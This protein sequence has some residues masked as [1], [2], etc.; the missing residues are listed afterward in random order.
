MYYTCADLGFSYRNNSYRNN[1]IIIVHPKDFLY[2]FVWPVVMCVTDNSSCCSRSS[3]SLDWFYPSGRQVPD[4]YTRYYYNNYSQ[5]HECLFQIDDYYDHYTRPTLNLVVG[6][7][8]TETINNCS[9][10]YRCLIPDRH[11][12]LQQLFLGIYNDN[13]ICK[14]QF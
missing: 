7:L 3:R 4:I 12:E 11:G 14:H 6:E 10:L 13:T 5:V 9:G 8:F 1:S 2:S